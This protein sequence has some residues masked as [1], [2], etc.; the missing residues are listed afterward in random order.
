MSNLLLIDRRI[1]DID[2]IVGSLTAETDYIVFD[3]YEDTFE[4]IKHRIE[5]PYTNVGIAQHNYQGDSCKILDK[6][7]PAVVSDVSFA[8]P[9]LATWDVSMSCPVYIDVDVSSVVMVDSTVERVVWETVAVDVSSTSFETVMQENIVWSQVVVDVSSVVVSED[10]TESVVWTQEIVDV[11]SAVLE[12][13]VQENIVWSQV[14]MDVSS[15]VVEPV[16]IESVAWTSVAVD[17][18]SA[19]ISEDGTESV[20]WTQEIRDVSSVVMR[21]VQEEKVIW[22]KERVEGGVEKSIGFIDFLG[23]LKENGAEHVDFLACFLWANENWRYVIAEIREKWGVWIRASIDITGWGGNFILESDGADMI[24]VYF[25]EGIWNY[26]H[27]FAT[28]ILTPQ[29]NRIDVSGGSAYVYWNYGEQLTLANAT[30]TTIQNTSGYYF[31]DITYDLSNQMFISM[32]AG[33]ESIFYTSTD[34]MT[35]SINSQHGTPSTNGTPGKKM[36]HFAGYNKYFFTYYSSTNAYVYT[37]NAPILSTSNSALVYTQI[38]TVA[39]TGISALVKSPTELLWIQTTPTA[40]INPKYQ[41]TTNITTYGSWQSTNVQFPTIGASLIYKTIDGV[42]TGTK[43]IIITSIGYILESTSAAGSWTSYP[44]YGGYVFTNICSSPNGIIIAITGTK[45]VMSTTGGASTSWSEITISGFAGTYSG[46]KYVDESGLFYLFSQS[47]SNSSP[48]TYMWKSSNGT[49]WTLIG[50]G[51]NATPNNGAIESNSTGSILTSIISAN[52]VKSFKFNSPTNVQKLQYTTD[53]TNYTDL[54]AAQPAVIPNYSGDPANLKI[55]VVDTTLQNTADSNTTTNIIYKVGSNILTPQLNRIDAS[56]TGLKIYWNYKEQIAVSSAQIATISA[57]A[58]CYNL[59]YNPTANEYLTVNNQTQTNSVYRSTDGINYTATVLNTGQTVYFIYNIPNTNAYLYTSRFNSTTSAVYYLPTST[60]TAPVQKMTI[61]QHSA[62]ALIFSPTQC[63]ALPRS[64]GG[65]TPNYQYTNDL[66]NFDGWQATTPK[67][68][69]INSTS[70]NGYHGIWA[71]TKFILLTSIGY[72]LEATNASGPWTSYATLGGYVLTGIAISSTGVIVAIT[73][74]HILV[75]TLGGNSANWTEATIPLTTTTM[76]KVYWFENLGMFAILGVATTNY[77]LVSNNGYN[78]S[79]YTGTYC[80]NLG[81]LEW[82]SALNAL[83]GIQSGAPAISVLMKPPANIQKIQYTN[84]SITYYDLPATQPAYITDGTGIDTTTVKVRVIDTSYNA[85]ADSNALLNPPDAPT[86]TSIIAS[87]LSAYIYFTSG[88]SGGSGLTL[89]YK[90]TLDNWTTT[91]TTASTT[92]PI[93][94]TGLTNNTTY[95]IGLKANNGT[96]DS[97]A[98]NAVSATPYAILQPQINRIDTSGTDLKLYFNYGEQVTVPTS[99]SLYGTITDKSF[100][101]I[102]Y[103]PNDGKYLISKTSTATTPFYYSTDFEVWTQLTTLSLPTGFIVYDM[104]W[105]QPA[106]R[107]IFTAKDATKTYIKTMTSS[108]AMDVSYSITGAYQSRIVQGNNELIWLVYLTSLTPTIYYN[109][110]PSTNLGTWTAKTLPTSITYYPVDGVWNGTKYILIANIAIDIESIG[111]ASTTWTVNA[112]KGPTVVNCIAYSPIV[113]II[114][115]LGVGKALYS[116]VGGGISTNWYLSTLPNDTTTKWSKI[117]WIP[118]LSIFVAVGDIIGN[119][120]MMYSKDGISWTTVTGSTPNYYAIYWNALT[121]GLYGINSAATSKTY[122]MIPPIVKTLQYTTDL[123]T[124]YDISA[125]QPAVIKNGTGLNIYNLGI[126]ALDYVDY[127]SL[128]SNDV[129]GTVVAGYPDAPVLTTVGSI[130]TTLIVNFTQGSTGGVS[131]TGYYYTVNGGSTWA[132]TATITSPITISGLTANVVYSVALKAYNSFYT[133]TA[134]NYISQIATSLPSPNINAIEGGALYFNYGEQTTFTKGTATTGNYMFSSIAYNGTR[135]WAG[136]S[137]ASSAN[138]L[139]YSSDSGKTWTSNVTAYQIYDIEYVDGSIGATAW[140]VFAFISG[141]VIYT[142]NSTATT[143]TSR[144]TGLTNLVSLAYSSMYLLVLSSARV[145]NYTTGS[146][147]TY[148]ALTLPAI[149]SPAVTPTTFKLLYVSNTN[150]FYAFGTGTASSIKYI[151]VHQATSSASA[152]LTTAGNW[153]SATYALP[154]TTV[155][156]TSVCWSTDLNKF[157]AVGYDT[158]TNISYSFTSSN[159]T[160]WITTAITDIT[161]QISNVIYEPSLKAFIATSVYGATDAY[162]GLIMSRDGINWKTII[163][164]ANIPQNAIIYD[165]TQKIIVGLGKSGATTHPFYSSYPSASKIQ[166]TTDGTNFTDISP[167]TIPIQIPNYAS[168]DM[169]SVAIRYIDTSSNISPLSSSYAGTSYTSL[170]LPNLTIVDAVGRYNSLL[171]NFYVSTSISN[172]IQNCKCQIDDGSLIDVSY[173]LYNNDQNYYA[174]VPGLQNGCAY[175]VCI[176]LVDI[177][178]TY[179][180]SGTTISTPYLYPTTTIVPTSSDSTVSYALTTPSIN[181]YL[182]KKY[183][184]SFNGAQYTD[185]SGLGSTN[186]S[187]KGGATIDTTTYKIGTGS[188]FLVNPGQFYELKNTPLFYLS[189]QGFSISCWIKSNSAP[190]TNYRL[191]MI[192]SISSFNLNALITTSTISLISG[193]VNVFTIS[194]LFTNTWNNILFTVS[195]SKNELSLYINGILIN[196][197]ST[198]QYPLV[199]ELYDAYF[200]GGNVVNYTFSGNV[201]D[202]RF[203]NGKVLTAAEVSTLY[204]YTGA[205]DIALNTDPTL[206]IHEPFDKYYYPIDTSFNYTELTNGTP[207]TLNI[208]GDLMD[209]NIALRNRNFDEIVIPMNTYQSISSAYGQTNLHSGWKLINY[210]F[211]LNSGSTVWKSLNEYPTSLVI[212]ANN[213]GGNLN[214]NGIVSQT[215]Y[216]TQSEYTVSASFLYSS[217]SQNA[218]STS[219][220]FKFSIGDL[221][222]SWFSCPTE[223][224]WN[225]YSYTFLIEVDNLYDIEILFS[226]TSQTNDAA[227]LTNVSITKLNTYTVSSTA[228]PYTVPSP[229]TINTSTATDTTITITFTDG[230][231]GGSP[232]TGYKISTDAGTTYTDIGLVSSPY[233]IT[234]LTSGVNYTVLLKSYNLAGDSLDSSSKQQSTTSSMT[235]PSAPT[236]TSAVGG[237]NSAQIFFTAGDTGGSPITAYQYSLDSGVS[238]TSTAT[239]TSPIT[240]TSPIPGTQYTILLKA[241]NTIGDSPASSA[242]NSFSVY[243]YPS[244]PLVTSLVAGY[245]KLTV[246]FIQDS[247]GYSPITGYKYS[248]NGGAY[249]TAPSITSPFDIS[250]GIS[251]GTS[252][253]LNLIATNLVD[254]SASLTSNTAIPFTKPDAPI[255]T[256]AVYDGSNIIMTFNAPAS[257]GGVPITKYSYS[258]DGGASYSDYFK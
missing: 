210:Y 251:I 89:S 225:S 116:L 64:P 46:I 81:A 171:V 53:G 213:V 99:A 63:I 227:L 121:D 219:Y 211:W 155:N 14:S 256:R 138:S 198:F 90:Y 30:Q 77:L 16:M 130:N 17:V 207:Y 223:N 199:Y 215:K 34:G 28:T 80:P 249:T 108:F 51:S 74:G 222:S 120:K 71:G 12:P 214:F 152:S 239:T 243:T 146:L 125:S 221:S 248:L 234:G 237:L 250:S 86:I 73:P 236:I 136:N 104:F 154:A 192:R 110:T 178:G 13:V 100:N 158:A 135:Y 257:N 147:T 88:Y 132:S 229:P 45:V 241:T 95:T 56:G 36:Y 156:I 254:S 72:I 9:E 7:A 252:Y 114:C 224:I 145:I 55:R 113:N 76:S 91:L 68:P 187:L 197:L 105:Y 93:V 246:K 190:S 172:E 97:A 78:W 98:S 57:S 176:Y 106:S 59:V 217:N 50:S 58:S 38:A 92:S 25:T 67:L 44:T 69:S 61:A 32:L 149:A 117:I 232:I 167:A 247:S 119:S 124:Y 126:R 82:S 54:S 157:V 29:L 163:D 140:N 27:A 43:Y 33:A 62:M 66:V 218:I 83:V 112:T 49:T 26:K 169:S 31:Y 191:F 47:G 240:I 174:I 8:D 231:T 226:N 123:A 65:L 189:S 87:N 253:T 94:L 245:E 2:G 37:V 170:S 150:K 204:N 1:P 216:L 21:A 70:Y 228:T 141:T 200:I 151:T 188:L 196:T 255:L 258:L 24:G 3:Y 233:T 75:S 177:Y 134:S 18:S 235:T 40:I 139:I 103:N 212:H 203:Y 179:Y 41:Y 166:Y 109:T 96:Y 85:T 193:T 161:K 127:P 209:E 244:Q 205:T 186:P 42:W 10:G 168:I 182:F 22:N 48:T 142:A 52:T 115:A 19:V 137:S 164:G 15:I 165:T 5:K 128:L 129:S 111:T 159:G 206:A 11:S 23:W 102:A 153:T 185:L 101:S 131:L 39:T 181:G 238:Y 194:N 144:K 201:D 79:A 175:K 143:L 35:F 180:Y 184:Y 133:S 208:K 220:L 230:S 6:M 148:T 107:Y 183:Q 162:S 242:S 160:T 195:P 84:D 4:S 202:F 20:V 122:P 60:S 173:Y 118:D